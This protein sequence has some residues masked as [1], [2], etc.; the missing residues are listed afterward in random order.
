MT[1]EVLVG[2]FTWHHAVVTIV[3]LRANFKHKNM[4]YLLLQEMIMAV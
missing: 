3:S 4:L 1:Q 2:A